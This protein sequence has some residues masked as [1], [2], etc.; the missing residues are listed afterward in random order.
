LSV[1]QG[2]ID[3]DIS[4]RPEHETQDRRIASIIA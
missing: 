3:P 4:G 2:T 1:C